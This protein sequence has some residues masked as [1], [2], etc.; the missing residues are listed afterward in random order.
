MSLT[1]D[2]WVQTFII[3]GAQRKYTSMCGLFSPLPFLRQIAKDITSDVGFT[4]HLATVMRIKP[5]GLLWSAQECT[6]LTCAGLS[7]HQHDH[8]LILPR[9]NIRECSQLSIK[10]L[11]VCF[12]FSGGCRN[13]WWYVFPKVQPRPVEA[14]TSLLATSDVWQ[15]RLPTNKSLLWLCAY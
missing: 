8:T 15:S 6:T 5:N 14:R 3:V 2:P 13:Q 10:D 12:K 4:A 7:T 9:R 11:P 1:C